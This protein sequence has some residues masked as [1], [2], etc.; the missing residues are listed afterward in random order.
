MNRTVF[1]SAALAGTVLLGVRDSAGVNPT[2]RP[3]GAI[4]T[5][6]QPFDPFA[7]PALI[8][9]VGTQ[10]PGTVPLSNERLRGDLTTIP[11]GASDFS[12]SING[13]TRVAPLVIPP[14]TGTPGTGT[15]Q[16]RWKLGVYSKDTE[17][18]VRIMQVVANSAAQRAGLEAN[19]VIVCVA[20]YQVGYVN[21]VP[22]DCGREFERNCDAD[23]WVSLLVQNN[24]DG[25]LLAMPIQLER[26]YQGIDGTITYRENYSLPR[27]A[28][29]TIELREILRPGAPPVTL[30]RQTVSPIRQI[31]IPY[32]VEYEPSQI[33]PRRTYVLHA[34]ITSGNRMLFATRQTFPVLTAGGTANVPLLVESTTTTQPGSP[35]TSRDEQIEQLVQMY[36]EYLHRDPRA[37][38]TQVW[39]SHF[40][41]G[42]SLYDAQAN[43][44]STSEFYNR[45]DSNDM[46][47]IRE[48]HTQ[49]LGKQPTQEELAYWL[50]RMEAHN[51]LRPEVARE[52]L[53]AVGVQR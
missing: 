31:P 8:P 27:D 52:F 21:G 22:Y 53:A 34:T 29:A 39:Q 20:G 41:R 47:Y 37:P 28:V 12:A 36:R 32:T 49:I 2:T 14:G 48:L 46:T 33:D 17:T 44:L 24:R 35:Y 26:R 4:P 5:V 13:T 3:S 23:G 11:G 42:G 30:A 19:D 45:C 38:E 6:P 1:F 15:P 43:L 9:G 25:K 7:N 18:G 40:D 51:R 16:Q 10:I 50:A